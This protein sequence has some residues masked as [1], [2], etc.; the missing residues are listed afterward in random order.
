VTGA[1]R[2]GLRAVW[3]LPPLLLLVVVAAEIAWA[4]G[5]PVTK[6]V[7]VVAMIN[8]ILVVGL[9]VFVGNSGVL[10]FGS[11]GFAAIGAYTSGLLVIPTD[12]KAILQPDLPG[13]IA[14]ANQGKGLGLQFLRHV[15]RTQVLVFLVDATSEDPAG[16][17]ATLVQAARG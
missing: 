5:G 9:Y 6:G 15:E 4:I 13:L 14:G 7:V 16:T 11:V 2:T 10:S 12:Q 17:L 8:L 3:P 1:L